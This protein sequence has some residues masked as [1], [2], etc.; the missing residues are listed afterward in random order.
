M[1]RSSVHFPSEGDMTWKA[2]PAE[3]LLRY[4]STW[5]TQGRKTEADTKEGRKDKSQSLE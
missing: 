4:L 5:T 1:S 2:S 3:K